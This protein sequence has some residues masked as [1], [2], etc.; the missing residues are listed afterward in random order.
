MSDIIKHK[1]PDFPV[2]NETLKKNQRNIY[3]FR[4]QLNRNDCQSLIL[5][6]H[7]KTES[8]PIHELILRV[9]RVPLYLF[10]SKRL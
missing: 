10:N 3:L 2:G 1:T 8:L 6:Y 5:N 9:F 4:I 7:I